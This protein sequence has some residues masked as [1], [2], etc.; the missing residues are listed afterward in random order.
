M[1][2]KEYCDVIKEIIEF[3]DVKEEHLLKVLSCMEL[4]PHD[5]LDGFKALSSNGMSFVCIAPDIHAH[6]YQRYLSVTTCN[7]IYRLITNCKTSISLIYWK[8]KTS[9]KRSL[10]RYDLSNLI[11]LI[12]N[13]IEPENIIVWEKI[14]PLNLLQKDIMKMLIENN[15]VKLLWDIGRALYGLHQNDII[16]GDARIDNIG[17]K[18]NNFVLFDFD[19]SKKIDDD[20]AY[21]YAKEKDCNDLIMSIKYHLDIDDTDK[22]YDRIK[23][24]IPDKDYFIDSFLENENVIEYVKGIRDVYDTSD[25]IDILDT[26]RL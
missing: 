6:V 18:N 14:E 5:D 20:R 24:Y 16:H 23:K 13:Y 19:A 4:S 7:T 3:G 12:K 1:Y 22:M 15:I 10:Y 8:D 2:K 21:M 9:R 17:I 25:I 26:I 11:P